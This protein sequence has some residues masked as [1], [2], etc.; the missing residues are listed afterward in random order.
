LSSWADPAVREA[1]N[2]YMRLLH[3]LGNE[4]EAWQA[5]GRSVADSQPPSARWTDNRSYSELDRV[6]LWL[7]WGKGDA[8][9]Q[10]AR[11]CEQRALVTSQAVQ[12]HPL[13]CTRECI[14]LAWAYLLEGD[15]RAVLAL[16]NTILPQAQASMRLPDV[17][18]A[19]VLEALAYDVLGDSA[20]A[21]ATL[22]QAI[23]LAEP[24]GIVRVFVDAGHGARRLLLRL[25]TEQVQSSHAEVP[26][27]TH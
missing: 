26:V 18:Q 19:L 14:A 25:H 16:T 22:A 17:L 23:A 8:V 13:Y 20:S 10:W 12:Q 1:C 15:I 24:E 27:L 21:L 5:V 2:T 9:H 11:L 4:D 7:L 6:H 3:A